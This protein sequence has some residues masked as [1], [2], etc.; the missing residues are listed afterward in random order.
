MDKKDWKWEYFFRET[1]RKK[2]FL[3]DLSLL[4]WIEV[5]LD[6]FFILIAVS[7]TL[8]H[9]NTRRT[10][11]IPADNIYYLFCNRMLH[12]TETKQM[13]SIIRQT[14]IYGWNRF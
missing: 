6:S 8:S 14:L 10:S 13:I 7:S 2:I 5:M 1:S 12:K 3:H 4:L 11:L 9:K